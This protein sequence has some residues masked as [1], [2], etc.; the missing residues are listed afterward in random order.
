MAQRHE[1]FL[2]RG[3]RVYGIS[4]DTA[5]MNA[6]MVD[7]LALPFPILSDPERDSA[8]IPLGFAD[9]KDPRKIARTALVV[10]DPEGRIV[11]SYHGR[12]FADRPQED[13]IL[14]ELEALGLSA[15]SQD[16]P[17]PGVIEAGEKAI[18]YDELFPY[19]RGAKFGALALRSR[20]RDLG[21]DF[22]VDA[23]EYIQMVDRYLEALSGVKE[24][25]A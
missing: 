14:A 12:D 17:E 21:E 8:I 15:T 20:H 3:A 2:Q 7:K 19:F 5:P 16:P 11:F 18:S 6:A 25:K 22:T 10:V 9:E 24:R 4:A 23:K 1:D 13:D